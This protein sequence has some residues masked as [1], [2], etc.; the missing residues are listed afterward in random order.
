MKGF[1]EFSEE[2]FLQ[3]SEKPVEIL[4]FDPKTLE[5]AD[6]YVR[7][8]EEL[9]GGLLVEVSVRGSVA[10]K[11]SGKG[12]IEVGIYTEDGDWEEVIARLT[13]FF[14][15]PKKLE[16]EYARFNDKYEKYH[17]EISVMRGET[18]ETDKTLYRF[19]F[20]NPSYVKEYEEVKKRSAFSKRE[21]QRQKDKFFRGVFEII[22]ENY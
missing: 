9:L 22:P 11:I 14:G 17:L 6:T 10:F 7:R 5:I 12:D 13:D 21:Y 2:Y 4:P 16:Q 8:I 3:F 1:P 20:D 15:E 18:A 19:L